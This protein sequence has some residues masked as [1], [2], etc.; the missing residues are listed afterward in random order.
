MTAVR[1]M[2]GHVLRWNHQAGPQTI[3]ADEYIST[4]ER[5]VATLRQQVCSSSSSSSS[6]SSRVVLCVKPD[7]H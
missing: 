1:C 3:P 7:G 4:L 2:Q 5:Q 6:S